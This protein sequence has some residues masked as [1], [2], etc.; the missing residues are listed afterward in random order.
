MEQYLCTKAAF[1]G[2]KMTLKEAATLKRL[3]KFLTSILCFHFN[4]LVEFSD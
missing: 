2:F 3:V 4:E 1:S